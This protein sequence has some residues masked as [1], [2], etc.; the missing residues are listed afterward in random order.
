[1]M[2]E[3]MVG[4]L[5]ARYDERGRPVRY[6]LTAVLL[7]RPYQVITARCLHGKNG[8][9]E[10][11][12]KKKMNSTAFQ[13]CVKRRGGNGGWILLPRKEEVIYLIEGLRRA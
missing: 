1:M 9:R 7:L 6:L 12:Y 3:S 2:Q 5:L 11:V 13:R 8:G 10:R 4:R